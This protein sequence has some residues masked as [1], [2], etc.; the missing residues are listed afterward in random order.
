MQ[1]FSPRWELLPDW[2]SK[3]MPRRF[4][5]P[6]SLPGCHA[7]PEW[8]SWLDWRVHAEWKSWPDSHVHPERG[9]KPIWRALAK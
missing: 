5:E 2:R 8:E 4:T 1:R 3:Q 9:S 6:E 7:L